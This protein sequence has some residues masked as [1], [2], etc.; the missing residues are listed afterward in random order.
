M[1]K[2]KRN[3]NLNPFSTDWPLAEKVEHYTDIYTGYNMYIAVFKDIAIMCIKGTIN[4]KRF[5]KE[6]KLNK[7]IAVQNGHSVKE[8]LYRNVELPK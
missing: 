1:N 5:A 4:G 7:R 3:V 6:C 8:Y 2:L